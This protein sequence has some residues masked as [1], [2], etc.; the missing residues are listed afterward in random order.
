MKIILF[1]LGSIGL[2]HARLLKEIGRHELVAFRSGKKGAGNPLGIKEISSWQEADKIRPDAAFI[3]NPTFLHTETALPCA[4][5]EIALFIEKPID[6][7]TKELEKLLALVRKSK[8]ASYVAYVLRFH[9]VVTALRSELD[10]K[11]NLTAQFVCNS[12]LPD[13]REGQNHAQSYS[14]RKEMGGGAILDVSHEFD[15]AA[16]LLGPVE[17]IKGS[18]QRRGTVTID[19]EDF[20]DAHVTC[21]SGRAQ[22]TI[23]IASRESERVITVKTGDG[24][25]R[26]DLL[27]G[28]LSFSSPEE[29]WQKEYAVERDD[30]YRSQ[31]RY[32]L[33]NIENP[34]MM[35]H[36]SE[37]AGLF[38]QLVAFRNGKEDHRP[39]TSDH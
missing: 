28:S 23:D 22:I 36:L 21:G 2:R 9:P 38:R 37:A 20:V 33:D 16:Y 39:V 18:F 10:E 32:F 24:T 1:G 19:A 7:S 6:R 4:E 31:L 14:A 26:A 12:W 35:N 15:L 27:K 11:K 30:P 25:Y 13:W 29:S 5:R 34:R 8:G 3:T 17:S